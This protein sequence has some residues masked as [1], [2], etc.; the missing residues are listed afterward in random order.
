MLREIQ[1]FTAVA[2][3]LSFSRAAAE[4]GLSQPAT[5]QAIGR[6]ERSLGVRLF[7]RTSREVRL[8]TQGSAL[9]G[10][11]AAV[12]DATAAF[13][14][15]GVRLARPSIR[16]AYPSL[17][18][19]LAARLARRLAPQITVELAVAGR[20]AAVGA[21][22]AGEAGAA[23]LGIPAPPEFTTAARFHVTVD[24]LA[25]PAGDPLAG[26][27][28]LR[29]QDLGGREL[30]LPRNRATGGAWARLAALVPGRHRIVA[31]DLDDFAAA[32]DLVAAGA[33][34]LPTPALVVRAVRRDDV[35]FVPLDAGELR[36]AYGLAWS[37]ERETPELLALV[38]AVQEA[39]WTR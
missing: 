33:G 2:R 16:L 38:Q 13:Q 20:S 17:V 37:K 29:P 5:S 27:P 12:L 21:L 14:A 31:D 32:L 11:A 36:L 9:L 4:L 10:H 15:E 1:A 35:R 22:A 19:T 3:H 23:I 34:A 18:G 28:R 25:L 7:D 24:H 26:S 30:L 39:L 8:T 6:L